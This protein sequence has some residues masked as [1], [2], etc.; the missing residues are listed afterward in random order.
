MSALPPKADI[1]RFVPEADSCTASIDAARSRTRA[2]VFLFERRSPKTT[3]LFVNGLCNREGEHV[4]AARTDN[5]NADRQALSIQPGGN[6]R[7][8]QPRPSPARSTSA[9]LCRQSH[10]R[11]NI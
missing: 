7:C 3:D 9:F 6:R 8:W 4:A 5:L 11:L 1:D 2:P 10:V